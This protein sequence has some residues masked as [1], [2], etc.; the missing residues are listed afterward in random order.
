MSNPGKTGA[1]L[2]PWIVI[3]TIILTVFLVYIGVS[4]FRDMQAYEELGRGFTLNSYLFIAYKLFG[5][6][7]AIALYAALACFV[8]WISFTV[9]GNKTSN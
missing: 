3:R 5:K 4:M 8:L 2:R 6:W 1:P 7:G 9:R